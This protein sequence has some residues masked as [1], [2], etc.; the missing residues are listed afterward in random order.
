MRL[1]AHVAEVPESEDIS[2][3]Q[4]HQ[5][6]FRSSGPP[7]V[8]SEVRGIRKENVLWCPGN[9][10]IR[11][12]FWVRGT[13]KE[14]MLWCPENFAERGISRKSACRYPKRQ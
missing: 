8:F 14:N 7:G 9:F 13:R 10:E 3:G 5:V 12:R 2:G 4:G 6:C 1:A 11:G